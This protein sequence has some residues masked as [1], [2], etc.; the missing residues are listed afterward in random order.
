MQRKLPSGLD[1]N[2]NYVRNSVKAVVDAYSGEV[3]FYV[4]DEQDPI[5]AAWRS[6]FPNLFTPLEQ[7]PVGLREHLRYPEDLFRIQTDV[8]SKY[9]IDPAFFFQRDGKAWSVAQ[10]PSPA[11]TNSNGATGPAAAPT[12]ETV[13]AADQTFASESDSAR[14]TPYYT[15][16]NTALPGEPTKNEFVLFRPF[17]PFSTNDTRTQLQAYM[18]ASSDP[19]TYGK[20]TTYVV[21]A[22][23]GDLPDGPLRV[24]S[25]AESTEEISRRISLDNVGDGGS[26][27]RFG[28]MQIIPVGDGLI[29]VRPYYVS[30]PQTGSTASVTEFRSVLVSY[31]DRAVLESTLSEALALL[32]PGFEGEINDRVA[33]P[34]EPTADDGSIPE[35]TDPAV[36]RS[37]GRRGRTWHGARRGAAPRPGRCPLHRSRRGPRARRP[38]RLPGQG[39]AGPRPRLRG[40]RAPR[41][42]LT[43]RDSRRRIVQSAATVERV[44]L[45]DGQ[46]APGRRMRSASSARSWRNWIW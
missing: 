40:R 38:R 34:T 19:T 37:V 35:D 2:D 31:N 43:R 29:Y 8:Y 42:H 21:E 30:V 44:G 9:R 45:R 16:F 5:L 17:V 15:V 33:Q 12:D 22:S 25:N 26:Q 4:V 39:R 1:D 46:E 28:D 10:A 14:F 11:P 32:F 41:R 27:V 18:T 23:D 24:A 7:M 36:G 20:L 3:T 6:A 13:S